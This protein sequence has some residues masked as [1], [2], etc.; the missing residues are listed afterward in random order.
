MP[1]EADG[2]VDLYRSPR[3]LRANNDY[4]AVQAWLSLQEAPAT[5]RGLP[6][7]CQSA[8]KAQ[9]VRP[10]RICKCL[11]LVEALRPAVSIH[12]KNTITYTRQAPVCQWRGR[13]IAEAKRP[14]WNRALR[15]FSTK[16]AHASQHP[17]FWPA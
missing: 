16:P 17:T 10:R 5:Q 4:D 2:T 13:T 6:E 8:P 11:S 14:G 9:A 1:H 7:A 3:G 12:K 15:A